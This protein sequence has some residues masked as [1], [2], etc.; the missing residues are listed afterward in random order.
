MTPRV[1]GQ[2]SAHF[3]ASLPEAAAR[4]E[5]FHS[6]PE[7]VLS[8]LRGPLRVDDVAEL[9]EVRD[10]EILR[11]DVEGLRVDHQELRMV[12]QDL[13]VGPAVGVAGSWNLALR[14]AKGARDTVPR[15][16]AHSAHVAS[17]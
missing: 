4:C 6:G 13:A 10:V 7:R 11:A 17:D 16:F 15:A 9:R 14:N 12:R 3:F 8:D 5:Y 1:T 2:R